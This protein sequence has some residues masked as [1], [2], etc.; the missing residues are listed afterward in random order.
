[1]HD[2]GS[3]RALEELRMFREN[4]FFCLTR[5]ADALLELVDA[6]LC[7]D[8][9]VASL[10]GL[11]LVPEHRRGHGALYDALNCGR[12]EITRLRSG[13]PSHHSRRR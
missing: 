8:G 11:S 12:V 5:R 2:P 9:P 13:S 3:E 7:A 4:F 10:A 1:M 6:V